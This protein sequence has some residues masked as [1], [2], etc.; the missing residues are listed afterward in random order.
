MLQWCPSTFLC[1]QPASSS[2]LTRF[3][4][5]VMP[6][7]D[8]QLFPN[9]FMYCQSTVKPKLGQPGRPA[10]DMRNA[11]VGIYYCSLYLFSLSMIEQIKLF[12]I[13]CHV[14]LSSN[15]CYWSIL[16]NILRIESQNNWAVRSPRVWLC[17][18]PATGRSQ[19]IIGVE[20][21]YPWQRAK[22][23][24]G[25]L[26]CHN[27][28]HNIVTLYCVETMLLRARSGRVGQ[29]GPSRVEPNRAAGPGRPC[30]DPARAGVVS[31]NFLQKNF[32]RSCHFRILLQI[33]F[34]VLR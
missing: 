32:P 6:Y 23:I 11:H 19:F 18:L 26:C 21:L 34:S 13:Q 17:L 3:R 5:V 2:S 20:Y 24:H 27:G 14:A 28:V 4:P 30:Q 22:P 7:N 29:K 12:T 33:F 1:R 31:C 25:W 15:L 16:N 10:C 9:P 8:K